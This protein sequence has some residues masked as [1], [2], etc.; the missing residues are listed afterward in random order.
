[1]KIET[2]KTV[3]KK[4]RIATI[5]GFLTTIGAA[6]LIDWDTFDFTNPAHCCKLFFVIAPAIGGYMS[7]IK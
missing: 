4:S 1:M 6:S 3:K 5:A 2:N 7:T